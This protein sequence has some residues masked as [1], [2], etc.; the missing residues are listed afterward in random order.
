MGLPLYFFVRRVTMTC[1]LRHGFPVIHE[2]SSSR[3]KS[4]PIRL[5]VLK[6]TKEVFHVVGLSCSKCE[7]GGL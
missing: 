7:K 5:V 1:D 2:L 4:G 6:W 3:G